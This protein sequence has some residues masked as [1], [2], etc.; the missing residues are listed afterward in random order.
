MIVAIDGP[1]ASGKG[2]LAR[3]LA[4]HYGLPHLDTGLLYR[5]VGAACRAAGMLG[6][7][8][9]AAAIARGLDTAALDAEALRA[10]EVGEAASV[11][12]AVPEVRA[13]LL[14]LQRRFA[15][16]PGGAVLDGRDIGTVICPDAPA[17]LFVTASPEVR[18]DR[19]HR[20]LTGRGEAISYEDVL[21]DIR[22]RDARDSGRAAAPLAQAQDAMLLDTTTLGIDEAYAAALALVESRLR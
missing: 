13:A 11:V 1:A 3:R 14:E 6:D 16:R 19:R 4:A 15:A 9:A 10:A 17:K 8:G 12:A 5:A 2:T 21:A 18:A 22:K 7:D 20:E